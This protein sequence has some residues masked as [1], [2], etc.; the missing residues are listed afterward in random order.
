MPP[1][2]PP[3][4]DRTRAP[5]LPTALLFVP[6]VRERFVASALRSPPPAVI[7]DL[8]DSIPAREK[9]EARRAIH[10][11]V[12]AFRTAGVPVFVRVNR[13]E[14][15]DLEACRRAMPDGVFLP[16]VEGPGEAERAIRTLGPFAERSIF[17][18]ATIETALGVVEARSIAAS[19]AVSALMFGV[20]DFVADA[21]F[22]LD[23]ESL[24]APA[25][26]VSLAA[27]AHGKIAI[28]L[29]DGAIGAVDDPDGLFRS[30]AQARRIGFSGSPVIHPAQLGPVTRGFA[31]TLDELG[32][33]ERV[34]EAFET[35]DGGAGRLGGGLVERPTYL[36]AL[37]ILTAGR[38][39]AQQRATSGEMP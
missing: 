15:A 38:A 36:R 17:L 21:G 16:K 10:P 23:A 26:M 29:A 3:T 34:V 25:T 9:A 39:T 14:E 19:A 7:L 24:R 35:S 28:G 11:A 37:A 20:G 31:P 13:R 8:E 1:P 2:G 30:A 5:S 4:T 22:A 18:V 32:A 27:R 12:A 33:A 6:V